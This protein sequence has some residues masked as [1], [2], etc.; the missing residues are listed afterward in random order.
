D[1]RVIA[2]IADTVDGIAIEVE[3]LGA[4]RQRTEVV[5]VKHLQDEVSACR[6][7]LANNT[8]E[9]LSSW[10]VLIDSL[11]RRASEIDD[12]VNA[13]SHEHGESGFKEI[14]WWVGAL[15]H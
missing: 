9:D 7:L 13:L 15:Q 1:D 3:R 6:K 5:T 14:R 10:F 12:I 11:S 8:Q 4:L 2:G